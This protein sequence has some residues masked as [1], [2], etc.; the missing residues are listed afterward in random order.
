MYTEDDVVPRIDNPLFTVGYGLGTG[1]QGNRN[2]YADMQ[3]IR[4]E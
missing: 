4:E 1:R 3:L 2:Y